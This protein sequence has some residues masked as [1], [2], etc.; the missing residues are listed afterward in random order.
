MNKHTSV[1]NNQRSC[2]ENF[3]YLSDI[4]T[5]IRHINADIRGTCN[6]FFNEVK[7]HKWSTLYRYLSPSLDPNTHFSKLSHSYL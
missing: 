7:V 3:W 5:F 6:K 4:I 2:L 1:D